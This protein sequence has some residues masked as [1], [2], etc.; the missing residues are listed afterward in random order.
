ML[1][2]EPPLPVL[3]SPFSALSASVIWWII[4]IPSSM[5][6]FKALR[7]LFLLALNVP[8]VPARA[9][10]LFL[11]QWGSFSN[12]SSIFRNAFLALF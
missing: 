6:Q 5:A 2:E 3:S 12:L 4:T 8:P 9:S 11:V 1:H 7:T 10:S